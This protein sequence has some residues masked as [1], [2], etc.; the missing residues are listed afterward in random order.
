MR[1]WPLA[2]LIGSGAVG[3]ALSWFVAQ[4]SLLG[5]RWAFFAPLALWLV[6]WLV[7]ARAA[8]RVTRRRTALIGVVVLA[9]AMRL[10]AA[11]GTT[12]SISNDLY[13]YGWDAHVQLS[14]IDPYRYPPFAP[15]LQAQR[16]PPFFPSPAGCHRIGQAPGCTTL[17]RPE[18]RTIYPPAAQAW[19][20]LVSVLSPGRD[21]RQWQLAGAAVDMAVIALMAVGLRRLGRDPVDA[22]W[23]ALSPVPVVEFAGNGHVDGLALLLLVAA[24]LALQRGRRAT[25]GLLLGLATMFKLYPAIAVAACWRRGRWRLVLA[26]AAVCVVGY[27]PHVAVVGAQVVGYL[28]GYLRE[29]HYAN[30]ARFLLVGVLPLPDP[31]ITALASILVLASVVWAIRTDRPPATG[32]AVLLSVAVLVTSPVQP[33]YAVTLAGIGAWLGAPWLMAPAVLAEVYYAAVILDEPHQVAVGRI[34]YGVALAVVL[35]ATVVSRRG[36]GAP[37]PL[38]AGDTAV[39]AERAPVPL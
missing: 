32:L 28:P 14:G 37:M 6:V 33:W 23:Y 26:A 29:E 9:A 12:P 11:S 10:A 21:V 20:D 15:Q 2:V 7:G 22:A 27:A 4:H 8:H 35:S 39:G 13:R 38:V 24:L 3:T 36:G 17:N 1:R 30:A 16:V 5:A 19:F 34:C 18:A 25:A 31:V